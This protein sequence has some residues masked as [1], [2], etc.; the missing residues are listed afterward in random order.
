MDRAHRDQ[1]DAP[2]PEPR[3]GRPY[4][5]PVTSPA[6][7]VD[8][9]AGKWWVLPATT[10]T[11]GPCI[12]PR[13]HHGNDGTQGRNA[14]TTGEVRSGHAGDIEPIRLTL[15]EALTLQSFRPDYP[16]QGTRT[17]RFRQI[18]NAVPPRLAAHLI[19]AITGLEAPA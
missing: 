14:R 13:C 9:K 17:S 4:E 7:T 19:T 6:P 2:Q 10:L 1:L 8:S 12:A 11:A 3:R 15:A 5:R 16:L 18:G